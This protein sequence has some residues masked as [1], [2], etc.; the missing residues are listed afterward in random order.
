MYLAGGGESYPKLN[1]TAVTDSW[2]NEKPD[3]DYNTKECASGKVCG[4]YTQ[5][6]WSKSNKVG[7]GYSKCSTVAVGKSI[8]KNVIIVVCNYSPA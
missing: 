6:V 2:Y 4:H 8:W 3:Y 5:V 1:M 7:C